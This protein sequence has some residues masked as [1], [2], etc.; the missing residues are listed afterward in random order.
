MSQNIEINLSLSPGGVS[1]VIHVSQYDKATRTLSFSLIDKTGTYSVPSGASATIRGTKPDHTGFEYPVTLSGAKALVDLQDQMTV[2]AGKVPCE[3]RITGSDG[4]ILG[5]ANFILDVERSALSDSTVISETDFPLIEKAAENAQSAAASAAQAKQNAED[6]AE[7]ASTV[8]NINA[9]VKELLSQTTAAKDAA[10]ASE[11]NAKASADAAAESEGNASES[12]SSAKSYAEAA[13]ASES[14]AKASAK[15]AAASAKTAAAAADALIAPNAGS[16]N[17]IY[18]GKNL[19]TEVTDEQWAAI[20]AGTFDDM[21]IGD[22]WVIS[23]VTWRIAA[24]DYYLHKGDT[25][26]TA[27]HATIV[28]DSCLYNTKYNDTNT[29]TGGYTGSV[30]YKSGLDS[31][32]STINSAFG[33]AHILNHRNYLTNAVNN[34][35]VPSGGAWFDST[36]EL[37]TERNVYGA[38]VFAPTVNGTDPWTNNTIDYSQYPLFAFDPSKVSNRSD[39]WLRDIVTTSSFA[40]VSSTGRADSDRASDAPLGVRP[41]FCIYQP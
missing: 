20:K 36:V 12:E 24:F 19:G 35:G 2:C 40:D 15:T 31:A 23:G 21:Y 26:C 9:N 39:W 4:S 30:L 14:N 8:I 38:P 41:A 7:S 27:H 3:I 13:A 11:T 17:A 32:K 16:H 1:P 37:M 29:T 22:Y 18:R 6:A 34:A 25:E 28:P 10:L 5:T 33:S